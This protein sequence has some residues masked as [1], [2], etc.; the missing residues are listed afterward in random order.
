MQR[1]S[2]STRNSFKIKEATEKF[3]KVFDNYLEEDRQ[4]TIKMMEEINF[5]F[6]I[7]PESWKKVKPQL[8]EQYS[9]II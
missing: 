3:G 4:N 6:S 2:E 7:G 8:L 9:K 1:R 5:A